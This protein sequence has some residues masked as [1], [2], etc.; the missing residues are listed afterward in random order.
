MKITIIQGAFFPV[1]PVRGGAVEKLWH[2]LAVEF[3]DLGH[4]VLH[5]SRRFHGLPAEGHENGVHHIRVAGFD[6]PANGLS[7]KWL[8]LLYSLRAAR[9]VP[10]SDIIVT[11]TFWAPVLLRRRKGVYVS[12]ERMPKGQMRLYRR[13][14]RLCACSGA[15]RDAILEEDPSARPRVRIIPNPLPEVPTSSVSWQEKQERILYVGRV[16]PEKGI[17]LLLQAFVRAKTRALPNWRLELV[18]PWET[19]DGGGGARWAKSLQNR[20]AREDIEWIG[21]LFRPDDLAA[22]YRRAQV[23]AYPSLAETGETF[24]L[25]PLE[26]MAWGAVPIVSALPCF[27]DFVAPGLNGLVFDHRAADPAEN[28]ATVFASLR[29]QPLE[30][31]SLEALRVRETHA[32]KRIAAQFLSDFESIRRKDEG[33]Q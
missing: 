10:V 33:D 21:P 11:N 28:L 4:E 26:A 12:V 31:L 29:Q 1:P 6:Q 7:L 3:A 27:R 16:H 25:A 30:K 8:D 5:I 22:R 18:G 15:V 24:G 9:Q 19:R 23:F 14:A 20:Y 2:R 32:P 13:A 17:E